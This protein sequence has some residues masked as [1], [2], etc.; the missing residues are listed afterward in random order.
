MDRLRIA[1]RKSRLALHQAE[2]VRA[3]LRR[4]Y[5]ETG[6][7][8]LGLTTRGDRIQDRP[9]AEVG[10]KGLFIKELEVA[11]LEKRA[12]LAVHSSKDLSA[13]VSAEFALV[14]ICERED[15]R[16]VLV[17]PVDSMLSG[18]VDLP[19]HARVGTASNRRRAQLLA[20]RPDL[21]VKP[22]RGNLQTRLA[23][24][25]A[26]DHDALVLAAAGLI[27]LGLQDRISCYFE[28]SQLLPAPGQGA[29]AIECLVENA[30]LIQK[31]QP[32]DHESTSARVTAERAVARLLEASCEAAMAAHAVCI[33]P[34]R[35][36][37]V[38]S[39]YSQDGSRQLDARREGSLAE[40]ET[41]GEQVAR[42][43]LAAGALDLLG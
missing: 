10:G 30:S 41:L 42:E 19:R 14:A 5:P 24:L 17:G 40:A 28:P 13:Q 2:L 18:L 11:L 8:I 35:L 26:G 7:D 21:Q 34:G 15:A 37:L 38:A 23:R 27:R 3:R 32:L 20:L 4:L 12:D 36:R 25:D 39:V 1:T 43:L 16:D 6:V 33:S 31:L 9:L 29:L 22:V